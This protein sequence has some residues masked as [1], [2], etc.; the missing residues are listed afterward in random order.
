MSELLDPYQQYLASWAASSTVTTRM[1][2]L[3]AADRALPRGLDEANAPDLEGWLGQFT[4]WTRCG[5]HADLKSFYRW[6]V[7]R[8]ELSHSPMRFLVTPKEPRREP[9]PASEEQLALALDRLHGPLRRAVLLAACEGL[10][11]AEIAQARREDIEGG[12]LTVERKGGK[13][14]HLPV[15]EHVWA[16]VEP[17]PDGPLVRR[18]SGEAYPPAKLSV[19]ASQ[20]LT[21][22]GL[23]TLTLHRFRHRFATML[24]L[25]R[26]LG[27]AGA[28]IRTVQEL[29]GHE[30][31]AST[32]IYTYVSSAARRAAIA[33]LPMPP[34]NTGWTGPG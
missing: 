27:G 15:Y 8:G 13:V 1:V 12:L 20:A 33:G 6:A 14:Q 18:R 7:E 10:R 16:D 11:C 28:D 19:A 25:P 23:P 17:L 2:V 9:R 21:A 34:A 22:I 26:E 4:G 3:R 29:M 31:L 30:S 32:Q 5:Y 24:L